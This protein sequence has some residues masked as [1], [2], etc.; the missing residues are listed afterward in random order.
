MSRLAALL[1]L[2]LLTACPSGA[3]KEVPLDP[4]KAEDAFRRGR[5]QQL[6]HAREP[7]QDRLDAAV[8]HLE[9]AVRLD[10]TQVAHHYYAGLAREARGDHVEARAHFEG[11]VARDEEHDAARWRLGRLLHQDGDLPGA[12]AQLEAARPGQL[13]D[14]GP[15][16]LLDLGRVLE[17]QGQLASARRRYEQAVSARAGETQAWFRLA[18]VLEQLGDQEG[19]EEARARYDICWE[20]EQQLTQARH[21]ARRA[22]GD[23]TAQR[24]V[25]RLAAELGRTREA[26]AACDAVLALVPEDAFA[27]GLRADLE[28]G[29]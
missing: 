19:A 4:S 20:V 29:Q 24:E 6:Q 1:L 8:E 10:A 5:G 13:G 27:A 9:E 11:A 3:P 23:A 28:R 15:T 17:D 26:L 16:L 7:S 25:A 22:P 2:P 21:A 12:R 14:D 18:H